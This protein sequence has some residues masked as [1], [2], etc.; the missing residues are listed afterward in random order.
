MFWIDPDGM[1][2]KQMFTD[3]FWAAASTDFSSSAGHT[4]TFDSTSSSESQSS[5]WKSAFKQIGEALEN[6]DTSLDGG[7]WPPWTH[8]DIINEAFAG[9][10]NHK[11]LN[12]L[13]KA[14]FDA[15]GEE[16]QSLDNSHR[17]A[18]SAPGQTPQEAYIEAVNFIDKQVAIYNEKGGEK[19]LEALGFAMHTLM[20]ASS[21][22]HRGYQTW[23]GTKGVSNFSGAIF[24][25]LKE[26][27]ATR[28]DITKTGATIKEFY[29]NVINGKSWRKDG[30]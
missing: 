7:D 23:Y 25:F 27:Q 30:F 11:E 9:V 1:L 21:P 19:G 17:H 26:S 4:S 5:N 3:G 6:M 18:M 29:Q 10:L 14:S 22:S 8:N 13:Y 24:H 2:S 12:I 16:F 15:D 28:N 20:D